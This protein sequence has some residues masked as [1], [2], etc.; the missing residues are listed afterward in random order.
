[1]R[2]LR[3][4]HFITADIM[5]PGI[6]VKQPGITVIY[7]WQQGQRRR[8]LYSVSARLCSAECIE[9]YSE[10]SNPRQYVT[11]QQRIIRAKG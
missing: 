4:T 8:Q 3:T 9:H 5:R 7:T 10:A 1:M 11:D 6:F 2:L